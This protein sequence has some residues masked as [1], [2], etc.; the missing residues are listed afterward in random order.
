MTGATE[1][2]QVGTRERLRQKRNRNRPSDCCGSLQKAAT[3]LKDYFRE[4]ESRV[5]NSD[6]R[7]GPSK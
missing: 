7:Q 6:L 3:V 2:F 1:H 5:Q 4:Q